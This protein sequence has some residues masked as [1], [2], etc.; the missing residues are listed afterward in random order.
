MTVCCNVVCGILAIV[1]AVI[2]M[3]MDDPHQRE[4]FV[5]YS[6]NSFGIGLAITCVGLILIGMVAGHM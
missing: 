3:S 1:F 6:W 5:G 4:K 2:A